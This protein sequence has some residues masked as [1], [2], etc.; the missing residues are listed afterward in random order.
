M[1]NGMDLSKLNDR[2][3][4]EQ[5]KDINFSGK[6]ITK[7][8]FNNISFLNCDFTGTTISTCNFNEKCEFVNCK[9]TGTTI[10]N[11]LFN[12]TIFLECSFSKARIEDVVIEDTCNLVRNDFINDC[13]F[14]NFKVR[15]ED[16]EDVT[17]LTYTAETPEEEERKRANAGADQVNEEVEETVEEPQELESRQDSKVDFK[18][19]NALFPQLLKEYPALQ[20]EENGYG[21][22]I[23]E[24]EFG[25]GPD[26]DS[27][28]WRYA[29]LVRDTDDSLGSD[30]ITVDTTK[31]ITYDTLKEAFEEQ[32]AAAARGIADK[33][34]SQFMKNSLKKFTQELFKDNSIIT[35]N[36][37]NDTITCSLYDDPQLVTTFL[38][39]GYNKKTQKPC[40]IIGKPFET[41]NVAQANEV[42]GKL[43]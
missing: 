29:F 18:L 32:L 41:N 38:A 43:K 4:Y 11:C 10:L 25:F 19:Y 13:T 20:Q 22:T 37:S 31:E 33:T 28:A 15:G 27:D 42:R 39:V 1:N 9:F 34:E 21:L 12:D 16:V 7:I 17:Q 23:D 3:E 35:E 26:N 40:I 30:V 36:L 2:H 24:I 5:F 14:I 6:H 8:K